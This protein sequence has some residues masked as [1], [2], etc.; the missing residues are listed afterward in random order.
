MWQKLEKFHRK[1]VT[2]SQIGVLAILLP[3]YG[4][5]LWFC[6][7][8]LMVEINLS[9]NKSIFQNNWVSLLSIINL[10]NKIWGEKYLFD[11]Q[12]N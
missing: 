11:V 7:I 10:K 8:D 1:L 5:L 2:S 6:P 3:L 12:S 9:K 4:L